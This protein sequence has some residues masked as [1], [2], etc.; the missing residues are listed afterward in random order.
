[1]KLKTI[2]PN[3]SSSSK[4]WEAVRDGLH[5]QRGWVGGG[6]Q[7]RTSEK[8]ANRERKVGKREKKGEKKKASDFSDG[9]VLT[10]GQALLV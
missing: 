8:K 1:M 2:I 6:K 5:C 10:Y 4:K 7:T 9:P 3:P